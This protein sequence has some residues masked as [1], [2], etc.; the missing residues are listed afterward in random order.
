MMWEL[1]PNGQGM[2]ALQMLNIIEGY[3]FSDIPFGSAKHLH[4]QRS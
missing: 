4:C 1:P 2:A 3:D